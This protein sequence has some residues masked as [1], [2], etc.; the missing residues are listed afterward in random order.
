MPMLGIMGT[1]R[2]EVESHA[3]VASLVGALGGTTLSYSEYAFE[4]RGAGNDLRPDMPIGASKELADAWRHMDVAL[5][6]CDAI[7]KDLLSDVVGFPADLHKVLHNAVGEFGH[8]YLKR[9][10]NEV[11][12]I[13]YGD[14]QT[15]GIPYSVLRERASAG[16]ASDVILVAGAQ[17]ERELPAWAALRA[18]L[19]STFITDPRFAW[20]VL[21][22]EF[23]KRLTPLE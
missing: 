9:S 3:L 2:R 13:D 12:Q 1:V 4:R 8:I 10:H 23:R 20:N 15:T 5:C 6:T 11:Q 14:Y 19:V 17:P 16:S 7:R 21:C 18:G 22:R